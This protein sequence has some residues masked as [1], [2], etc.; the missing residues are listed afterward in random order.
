MFKVGEIKTAGLFLD[1]CVSRPMKNLFFFFYSNLSSSHLAS[2]WVYQNHMP[3]KVVVKGCCNSDCV[4]SAHFG[5]LQFGEAVAVCTWGSWRE[6]EGLQGCCNWLCDSGSVWSFTL[7]SGGG[8]LY[9][10]QLEGTC[11]HW[12]CGC[13]S[14]SVLA[15]LLPWMELFQLHAVFSPLY[16][17]PS[18]SVSFDKFVCRACLSWSLCHCLPV[19]VYACKPTCL[20]EIVP[21]ALIGAGC[22]QYVLSCYFACVRMCVYTCRPHI[23]LC[24]LKWSYLSQHSSPM[25][26]W[27][28]G[29]RG[30]GSREAPR[31]AEQR[32]S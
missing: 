4:T 19:S 13:L 17:P 23:C 9:C 28:E 27:M 22:S 18:C 2:I 25:M 6:S 30:W 14:K 29:R 20:H 31:A 21:P 15:L 1:F 26:G 11:A 16:T 8:S 10:R 12:P 7:C 32:P 5:C 24:L 3:V